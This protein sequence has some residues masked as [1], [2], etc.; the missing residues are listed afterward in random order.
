M[1]PWYP[2]IPCP[3]PFY[4]EVMT[5]LLLLFP[6]RLK[7]ASGK[8]L[9]G[10]GKPEV[11]PLMVPEESVRGSPALKGVA[12]LRATDEA[13]VRPLTSWWK[14]TSSQVHG[15]FERVMLAV[16]NSDRQIDTHYER[17]SKMTNISM[18]AS[19]KMENHQKLYTTATEI[20]ALWKPSGTPIKWLKTLY[21]VVRAT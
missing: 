3:L 1:A 8:C 18:E 16:I 10:T 19:G 2:P 21:W 5:V 13:E 12:R 14:G 4:R 20:Q 17:H 6:V 9:W 11:T 7:L 15:P